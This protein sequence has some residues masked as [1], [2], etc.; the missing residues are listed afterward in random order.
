MKKKVIADRLTAPSVQS[1]DLLR[2]QAEHVR[3]LG[4]MPSAS[5]LLEA[6][7]RWLTGEMSQTR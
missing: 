2:Q 3:D 7:E 5:Q 4:R 6:R 1:I